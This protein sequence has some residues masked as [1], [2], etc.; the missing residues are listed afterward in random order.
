MPCI[1]NNREFR[2]EVTVCWHGFSGKANVEG[3][4]YITDCR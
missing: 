4:E 2:D 1:N 3:I